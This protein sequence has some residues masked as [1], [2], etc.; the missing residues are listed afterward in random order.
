MSSSTRKIKYVIKWY[1]KSG[2]FHP[3]IFIILAII[4]LAYYAA[5]AT[6]GVIE[7]TVAA[8]DVLEWILLPIYALSTGLLF[9]GSPLVTIFEI[10]VFKS[11]RSLFVGKILAFFLSFLPVLLVIGLIAYFMKGTSIILPLLVRVIVYTSFLA[12]AILLRNQKASLLYFIAVFM[13][14]PISVSIL[15]NTI[16][17]HGGKI[18]PVNSVLFYYLA[19]MTM[20]LYKDYAEIPLTQG[21]E[22]A[23]GISLILTIIS[24]EIFRRLEYE[25][26]Y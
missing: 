5:L 21:Y 4:A 12:S 19:P 22:I 8:T 3:V 17:M 26:Y 2:L 15:I 6:Y 13:I 16:I 18:D 7:G 10:D 14:L 24:M 1:L 20:S 23:L 11:W 9:I 25:P